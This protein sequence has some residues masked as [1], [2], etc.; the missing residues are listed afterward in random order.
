MFNIGAPEALVIMFL[1]LVVLGPQRLPEA[2]KQVGR[3]MGEIRKI[4][5]GFQHELK[6]AFEAETETA[7]RQRGAAVARPGEVEAM[8]AATAGG[9]AT[10]AEV[11]PSPGSTVDLAKSPSA[12]PSTPAR[13]RRDAPL[14]PAP[15]AAPV[16]RAATKKT[17]AKKTVAKKTVAKK[18][19][20]KKTAAKKTAAARNGTPVK[21][22]AATRATR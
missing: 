19:T 11:L 3:F 1:A 5:S 12:K 14:R 17:V 20:A 13:A 16:T 2:A 10:P 21:K 7:A 18:T 9:A 6:T 22:A 15:R 4:S 8:T